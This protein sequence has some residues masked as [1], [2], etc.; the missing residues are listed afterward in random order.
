MSH[1]TGSR[2]TATVFLLVLLSHDD[3]LASKMSAF[4]VF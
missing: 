3:T 4:F 1:R 2:A